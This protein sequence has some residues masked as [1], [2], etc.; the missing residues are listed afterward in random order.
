MKY[1]IC[2]V[3]ALLACLSQALAQRYE[4]YAG[5][6]VARMSREELGSNNPDEPRDNETSFRNGYGL[7]VRLTLNTRGYYGHELFGFYNRVGVHTIVYDENGNGSPADTKVRIA[8]V[9]YNFLSYMMPRGSRIRPFLTV[10]L[11]AA[12]HENPKITGWSGIGTRNYGFNYGGGIKLL[13]S[14][15]LLLRADVRDYITGKPYE[16]RFEDITKAGGA[17]RQQEFSFGL[18]FGF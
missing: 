4:V 18:A 9:G 1:P 14:R 11:H 6:S 5:R 16:L 10:G 2:A 3:L 15:N 17:I 12:Q 13:L 7:G 8:Q